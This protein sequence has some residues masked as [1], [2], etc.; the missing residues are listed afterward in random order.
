VAVV[1]LLL[2]Y[3]L[4]AGLRVGVLRRLDETSPLVV[5]DLKPPPP[6]QPAQPPPPKPRKQGGAPKN[7]RPSAPAPQ[8]AHPAPAPPLPV[9]VVPTLPALSSGGVTAG[10]A[11]QGNGGAGSGTGSGKGSGAGSGFTPARQIGGRFRNSDFPQSARDAGQRLRISVRYAV[12]PSGNVDRCE[13]VDSSGYPEVDAMTCRVITE[14]YRFKPAHDGDGYPVTQ[15][16]EEDY[17]WRMD[18]R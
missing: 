3:A 1:H 17:S 6:P 10:A 14:R 5:L 4:I 13:I 2:A 8:A 12:G 9:P 18:W 16:M 15:V 11:A 7:V